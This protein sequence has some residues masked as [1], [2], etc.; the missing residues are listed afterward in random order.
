MELAFSGID[1]I[2]I[3]VAYAVVMLLI[4][5]FSGRGQSDLHESMT[6][7]YLA[8]KN[9]GIIA[10]FFT[11]FATQYS[12]N[13]VVGYAPTA[14]RMGFSWWQSVTFMTII[15]GIYLLFA[16]RLY[17]ISKK[18]QFVTPTEWLDHR[19]RSKGVSILAI[20]F[21]LWGL[22]N[23]LL[24][25]LV[26]IGQ[27][28]SGLTGNTIPYQI[29]VVAF[30][31]VMLAYEWM[32]GMRAVALTDVMQGIA[33]LVGIFVLLV[34]GLYLVGG[35]FS[36][37]T[38]YIVAHEPQKASVP[39]LEVS[40]NWLSMLLLVGFGAAMYPHAIQRIYSAESE[41]TL[42][43]SF[44]RMAWM[45]LITTGLVFLVGLIGIVLFP[46]LDQEGSEQLVGLIANKV[47]GINGFFYWMM[48]LL[49][50][51]I[52]AAIVSTADSALLSFSS[53]ISKD[54]YARFINPDASEKRKI[55]VGK[56]TGVV[57]VA[58]LLVIA[59]YPPATLYDIFVLKLELLIQVA[60]AF[61]LG[62]YWKR[63]AAGPVFWGMLAGGAL[64]GFMTIAKI[65]TFAGIHGGILGLLLNVLICVVGSYLVSVSR[66]QQQHV[67]TLVTMDGER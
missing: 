1:A 36:S 15:I 13:N 57:A 45:P 29:A 26:A 32:G 39:P 20:F 33:L 38:S 14:Y 44:A 2:M 61:I 63:L 52:I 56:V 21:M 55:M 6:N 27:G 22:G 47:A 42:K 19:F 59:W 58:V 66:E 4:G 25:Q 9:L 49:F 67:H 17:V 24:E 35:D 34:G 23:Y 8:G 62:L 30:V 65:K 31:L 46:G 28:I 37:V 5:F 48:V 50:G 7:Y 53:M 3:L 16:P 10:L 40:V 54:V 60:P 51:G 11:L 41:R 12:G 43:R 18:R 64:A